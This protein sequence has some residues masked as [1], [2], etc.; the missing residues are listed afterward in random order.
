MLSPDSTKPWLVGEENLATNGHVLNSP[1]N[2][3]VPLATERQSSV[4][5][6]EDFVTSAPVVS[7]EELEGYIRDRKRFEFEDSF[8][9]EP[10][11]NIS[12]FVIGMWRLDA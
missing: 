8:G 11:W 10:L 1:D 6:N 9:G 12:V 2:V 4:L 7:D 3:T 5:D